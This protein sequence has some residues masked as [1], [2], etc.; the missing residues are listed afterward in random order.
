MKEALLSLSPSEL[1]T[2][3]SS[4][5]TGRLSPPYLALSLSRYFVE[6]LAAQVSASL[7]AMAAA[8][9]EP[10]A[11]AYSLELLA[12]A[13]SERPSIGEVVDL[14]TTGPQFDGKQNRETSVVV[15]DLFRNAEET[16]LVAGYAVYQGQKVFHALAER[17]IERPALNVRMFLDIQRKPGDTSASAELVGRFV[18]HF[19]TDEWPRGKPLP[20]VFYDPRALS[21][22][23]AKR[24]AL[25]AKCVVTD[26]REI[27]VSSA[28][29]T[30]AAQE[31][32]V[33]VG[34]LL[35]SATIAGSLTGFFDALCDAGQFLKAL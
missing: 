12:S 30:E 5:R 35:H 17:M 33:E 26:C 31:R 28:N 19:R 32:N 4:M 1:K 11:A 13:L 7:Q 25:H 10:T 15:E 8:G 20:E 3:A 2:L 27:F 6:P 23:R 24:T 29:F 22:D 9:M 34:L 16:I 21:A 18:N 14:V